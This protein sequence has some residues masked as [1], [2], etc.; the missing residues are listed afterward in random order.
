MGRSEEG[1]GVVEDGKVVCEREVVGTMLEFKGY[2]EEQ[3]Q[4]P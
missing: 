3:L 1:E 4:N 2:P